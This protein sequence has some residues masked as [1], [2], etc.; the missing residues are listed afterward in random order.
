MM[1][2]HIT[3][4]SKRIDHVSEAINNCCADLDLE[5]LNMKPN[6]QS[7][8]I[9]QILDHIITTNQS[10][11]P[12]LDKLILG[13]FKVPF[14]GK[15]PFL[16]R[17]F[18]RFIL[19]GVSP[20]REKKIK[21]FPVWEPASSQLPDDMVARFIQHQNKLKS[22]IEDAQPLIEQGATIYSPAS[23]WIVYSLSDAFEIMVTH[24]ERHLEQVREVM[25]LEVMRL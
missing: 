3:Q 19:K 21:T 25:R 20:T 5:S 24:E 15:L 12:M 23:K 17:F 13:E 18:G 7:W 16:R 1:E 14:H 11:F 8:S 6:L 10:Y 9:A 4:W 22:R 2:E